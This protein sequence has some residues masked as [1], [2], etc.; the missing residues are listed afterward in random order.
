[1][2]GSGAHLRQNADAIRAAKLKAQGWT[3]RNIAEA[4]GKRPE[5]I[6][7]LVILGER[8]LQVKP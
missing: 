1:M 5:Q 4:I 2:S 8:L 7:A 6:K 3:S